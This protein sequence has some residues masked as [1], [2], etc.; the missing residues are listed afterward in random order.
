M[1]NLTRMCIMSLVIY[2][3]VYPRTYAGTISVIHKRSVEGLK[4][5][6]NTR[7]GLSD[8]SPGGQ[9][10]V[11]LPQINTFQFFL[12]FWWHYLRPM[13]N[14]FTTN[15][16]FRQTLQKEYEYDTEKGF[17]NELDPFTFKTEYGSSFGQTEGI[18]AETAENNLD[19]EN[20]ME[21][22]ILIPFGLVPETNERHIEDDTAGNAAIILHNFSSESKNN[23]VNHDMEQSKEEQRRF[24]LTGNIVGSF[25]QSLMELMPSLRETAEHENHSSVKTNDENEINS[26]VRWEQNERGP[27]E[28]KEAS[29]SF[30][31]ERVNIA[32]MLITNPMQISINDRIRQEEDIGDQ[33]DRQGDRSIGSLGGGFTSENKQ[34]EPSDLFAGEKFAPIELDNSDSIADSISGQTFTL[35]FFSP[36]SHLQNDQD[37]N[38]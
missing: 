37:S 36:N 7:E 10:T 9:G 14:V 34:G 4:E 26:L 2:I 35:H 30:E 15:T 20:M 31:G 19:T 25:T 8:A 13:L 33:G 21:S 27:L 38:T 5:P 28:M 3:T 1:D 29:P 17:V 32:S 24:A 16:N 18:E 11:L 22:D 12:P 6:E 23:G